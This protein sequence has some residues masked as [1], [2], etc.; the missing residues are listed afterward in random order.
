MKDTYQITIQVDRDKLTK[1]EVMDLL[2]DKY[3][4][5]TQIKCL[6]DY[7]TLQQNS[8]LHLFFSQ[9]AQEFNDKHITVKDFLGG[10]IE[11]QFTPEIVKE[12]WRRIQKGAFNKKS[13][14]ELSK[15]GE[16]DFVYDALNL[17]ISERY[18]GEVILPPFPSETEMFI[19]KSIDNK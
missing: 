16:I 18:K 9:L 15:N 3:K 2:H 14:T 5:A 11:L 12:V 6:R 19:K 13:T 17:Y 8:A 1:N 7:R 4:E 10:S